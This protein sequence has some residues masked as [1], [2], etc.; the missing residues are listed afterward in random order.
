MRNPNHQ[1]KQNPKNQFIYYYYCTI[2]NDRPT[3]GK[4]YHYQ[5]H[6]PKIYYQKICQNVVFYFIQFC[7]FQTKTDSY[8]LG[9]TFTIRTLQQCSSWLQPI[10]YSKVILSDVQVFPQFDLLHFYLDTGSFWY[11][12][13]SPLRLH[14]K[15][16]VV[17]WHQMCH[18]VGLSELW[19]IDCLTAWCTDRWKK[20][21]MLMYRCPRLRK[22]CRWECSDMRRWSWWWCF[23][24]R[25]LWLYILLAIINDNR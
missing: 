15:D 25:F 2:T 14:C 3:V 8:S 21:S 4:P 9:N 23:D 5:T 22:W 18:F 17:Y 6:Q 16:S 13:V 10:K 11:Q 19:Q 7:Q 1:I 24:I 12:L 20:A